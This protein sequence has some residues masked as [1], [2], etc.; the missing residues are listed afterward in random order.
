[1]GYPLPQHQQLRIHPEVHQCDDPELQAVFHNMLC[2]DR[3]ICFD[4]R[5]IHK[6]NVTCYQIELYTNLS[7]QFQQFLKRFL[8][9]PPEFRNGFMVGFEPSH[10]PDKTHIVMALPL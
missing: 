4:L 1:M 10:Q 8:V 5:A 6:Q 7:T 2:H 9:L 3:C